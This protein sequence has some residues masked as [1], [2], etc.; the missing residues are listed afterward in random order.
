MGDILVGFL[1]E[2]LLKPLFL[3]DELVLVFLHDV[4]RQMEQVS[5]QRRQQRTFTRAYIA[6][7]ADKL[8]FSYIQVHISQC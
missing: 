5:N 2:E 1:D 7:N 4:V 3:A 8:S 6:D